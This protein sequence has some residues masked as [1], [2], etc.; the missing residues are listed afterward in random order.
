M[1]SLAA[2]NILKDLRKQVN[3]KIVTAEQAVTLIQDGDMVATGGFVGI[4]VP[5]ELLIALEN[6]YTSSQ[7]PKNISLIYAAGQGDGKDR[8]LNHLAHEGLIKRIIGGHY[9]LTPK[10]QRL[11][12]DNKAEAY[13]LPQGVIAH[14]FRDI[15]AGKPGVL[16]SVGLGTFVDPRF[17]GGKINS[18]TTEDIVR[19]MEIDGSE[20]LFYKAPKI[21]VALIRA[22]TA[23]ENGNLT[24]ER[25]ALTLETLA[26]ATAAKNSGGVVI[27][28]VERI[29]QKNTLLPR[30]VK[31]PGILVDVVVVASPANHMQTFGEAF[32]AAYAGEIRIPMGSLPPMGMSERKV[33]ARRAAMELV[34]NAVVNLGIGMP[35]GVAE[36]AAEEGMGGLFTLTAEPG[37]I[38]GIPAGGQS[39]GAGVN[40]DAI[41]DQ[42]YQFDFYDGGGLDVTFL[43]L[44]QA[45]KEGNLNVSKFGPKLAGSGGFINISQNAKKVVYVG[46]FTAGGLEVA[47]KDGALEIIKEGKV[48]KMVAEVEH[49]T[50]SGAEAVRRGQP[51]L[52]ITERCVFRLTK[53]GVE[54]VEVAP[55]VDIEKD[56]LAHMD[57]R[58]VMKDKI[59]LM[60]ARIFKDAPMGLKKDILG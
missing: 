43:G 17:G 37:V 47:V 56:I 53:E 40:T 28:Q 50:F 11:A 3:G 34:P 19:V 29:A 21:N 9:G 57:F 59:P 15:G 8:G 24:M 58:P 31:V 55:G 44:A 46:T 49:R 20:Y 36:V 45:D 4:G 25:E 23:D 60:D 39:F 48:K 13:N 12:L 7:S 33:I 32:S 54:L 26:M 16:S 10:L 27:A 35:E 1:T 52:Y 2:T 42:P 22:T 41:L 6:R 14:M 51:V 30:Q 5:E 18:K 38:G